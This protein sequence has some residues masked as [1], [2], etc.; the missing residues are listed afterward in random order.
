MKN[1]EIE[2][3]YKITKEIFYDIMKYVS[4]QNIE[5][6]E[7]KQHDV[8]FSPEHFPFFGGDIDNECLRLRIL[9]EK[10]I[11]S[12][13]KFIPESNKEP[14]HCIEHEV[15]IEDIANI[16][17]ILQDLRINE[18]FTLKKL[19]KKIIYKQM[20]EISLDEIENLGYFIELEVVD[21]DKVNNSLLIMQEFTDMFKIDGSM[22]NYDGYAYL[23]YEQTK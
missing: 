1:I 3:K 15:E 8:Y 11:L 5:L 12:Y 4:E 16:K 23:L 19:R 13:K 20:I 17:L 2:R 21:N 22:R 6:K 9:D 10:N 18:A 7:E 14:A